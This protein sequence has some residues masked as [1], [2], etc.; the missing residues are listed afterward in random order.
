MHATPLTQVIIKAQ[1]QLGNKWTAIAAMLPGRTDNAVKNRWNSALRK[2]VDCAGAAG[3]PG[4]AAGADSM[5][6][7]VKPSV[8]ALQALPAHARQLEQP[9]QGQK[10][11]APPPPLQRNEQEQQQQQLRQQHQQALIAQ[12]LAGSGAAFL[13]SGASPAFGQAAA[14]AAAAAAAGMPRPM[15]TLPPSSTAAVATGPPFQLPL[16]F[17]TLQPQMS[18]SEAAAMLAAANSDMLKKASVGTHV[19]VGQAAGLWCRVPNLGVCR[20]DGRL[21][22]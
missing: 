9:G 8:A 7:D 13:G 3:V 4:P 6:T 22:V 15:P 14:Q 5:Q 20:V 1:A 17:M 16:P 2:R 10:P 11:G 12:L 21:G 18:A 19:W